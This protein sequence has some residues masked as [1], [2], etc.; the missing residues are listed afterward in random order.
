MTSG[1]DEAFRCDLLIADIFAR[2][3]GRSWAELGDACAKRLV[4]GASSTSGASGGDTMGAKWPVEKEAQTFDWLRILAVMQR[5][6]LASSE[7]SMF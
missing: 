5:A 4:H 7:I 6:E 3:W 2:G 1:T